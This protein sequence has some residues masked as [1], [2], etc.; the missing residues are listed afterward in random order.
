MSRVIIS[1][2]SSGV[3][4]TT[5]T[6]A[7]LSLLEDVQPFKIGPD[8]I[9]PMLHQY[10]TSKPS[11]NLDSYIYSEETIKYLFNKYSQSGVSV[12]EGVMGLYDGKNHDL[13]NNSTAHMSRILSAPVILVVN[14]NKQAT[15]LAAHIKGLIEFDPRVNVAGVILNKTTEGSY[16]YLKAAIEMHLKIKCLGYLPNDPDFNIKERHLG[17]MQASEISGLDEKLLKLKEVAT[18]TLDL[19]AIKEIA[20]TAKPLKSEPLKIDVKD[21]FEG[22]TVAYAKDK[23]FSFIYQSH[24]DLFKEAG[25]TVKYFSPLSDKTVPDADLYILPG[26]YPELF[27]KELTSNTSMIS[28]IRELVKNK[29]VIAECGG[30]IY[31]TKGIHYQGEFHQ[32][33]NIYDIEIEFNNK[34]DIKRFGYIEVKDNEDTIY[35]HEFHYSKIKECHESNMAYHIVNKGYKCGYTK[36]RAIAGYP[37]LLYYS[38]LDYFK[39]IME[40]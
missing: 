7:I 33:C 37:H 21:I 35:G 40:D 32:L 10:V 1:G 13:E 6:N 8:F 5:V 28:T 22:K 12:L 31:L 2:A 34:L 19:K 16:N 15:S 25:A 14:A 26:G 27:L 4:K 23:A 36:E 17:L 11:Y 30:F 9:D 24:I 29:K 20:M 38:N 39:K 18:K 3:G